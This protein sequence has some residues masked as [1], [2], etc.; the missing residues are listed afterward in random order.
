MNHRGVRVV[1]K[2]RCRKSSASDRKT[3]AT[4][5]CTDCAGRI[6]EVHRVDS[7]AAAPLTVVEDIVENRQTAKVCVFSDFVGRLV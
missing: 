4:S 5:I 1:C 2:W 7:I 6:D 3:D